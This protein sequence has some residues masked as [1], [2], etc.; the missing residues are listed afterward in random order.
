MRNWFFLALVLG[1]LSLAPSVT[2]V[3]EAPPRLWH[4]SP[5]LWREATVFGA[6]FAFLARVAAPIDVAAILA[7]AVLALNLRGERWAMAAALLFLAAL[8]A[9]FALVAPANAVLA[10]W[11][12]GPIPPGFDAVRLRWES[13][14]AAVAT[15]KLMGY[16]ALCQSVLR[17]G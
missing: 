6:Q 5:G 9:W 12:P 4:W 17:R 11:L 1:A 13:G 14:H 7:T 8:L 3:L 16:L 10:T 2:H 15:L